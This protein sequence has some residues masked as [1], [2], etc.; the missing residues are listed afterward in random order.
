M[1]S[2]LEFT[3]EMLAVGEL[4]IERSKEIESLWKEY[5]LPD[6]ALSCSILTADF[7]QLGSIVVRKVV[8]FD[9]PTQFKYKRG[10]YD[11]VCIISDCI[12]RI[13]W[14]DYEDI[15]PY[16][17]QSGLYCDGASFNL[18]GEPV[19]LKDSYREFIH[20]S[21]HTSNISFSV[22]GYHYNSFWNCVSF[23]M[24]IKTDKVEEFISKIRI[25]INK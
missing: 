22:K 8:S 5:A 6:L 13:L 20:E 12:K 4:S 17:R 9:R 15:E 16:N 1:P 23:G 3:K 10:D 24:C 25:I 19:L 7:G 21:H 11:Y 2:I 18:L 14:T